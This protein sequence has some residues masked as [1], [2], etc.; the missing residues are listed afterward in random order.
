MKQSWLWLEVGDESQAEGYQKLARTTWREYMSKCNTP[1]LIERKGLEP[2]D[3]LS[4]RA[5]QEVKEYLQAEAEKK[6][7]SQPAP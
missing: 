1:E 5:H 2:F 6:K 3:T 4:A 7:A